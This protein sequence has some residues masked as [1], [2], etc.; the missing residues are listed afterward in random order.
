MGRMKAVAL[1]C[2]V[3]PVFAPALS[4]TKFAAVSFQKV[5]H[6]PADSH[7]TLAVS[8]GSDAK[9]LSGNTAVHF[10]HGTQYK[11]T[12]AL[13]IQTLQHDVG[14]GQFELFRQ[15]R[16]LYILIQVGDVLGP[17]VFNVIAIVLETQQVQ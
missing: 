16:L 15:N 10:E 3:E 6:L 2:I 13:G 14:T 12:A 8:L 1:D 5:S 4:T 17:A 7:Q 11:N 9:N